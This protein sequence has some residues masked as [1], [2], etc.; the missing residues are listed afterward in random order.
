MRSHSLRAVVL[1]LAVCFCTVGL[2]HADAVVVFP[3]DGSFYCN[4]SSCGYFGDN[5]H[6]SAPFF[7]NGDFFT[8]IFFT[9]QTSIQGFSY[10]FF[11]IDN[12]GGNSGAKYENDIYIN[13]VLVGSFSVADCG[14]CGTEMELK[15]S[16][17]FAPIEGDGTYAL[18]VVLASTVPQ[19]D[20][21]EIFLAPGSATLI[22][23]GGGTTPEPGSIFLLGSG[24]VG[25]AGWMRRKSFL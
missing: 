5:G 21:N 9:G 15:G 1:L 18:S 12:L 17:N 7:T 22:D 8:E 14:Y 23:S 13:S 20:G 19:G 3:S 24:I 4:I 25:L 2:A 16:F 6:Q 11:F 10:D